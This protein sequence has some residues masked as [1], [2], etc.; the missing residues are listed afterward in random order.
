MWALVSAPVPSWLA[1]RAARRRLKAS[2][3]R[4]TANIGLRACSI[5]SAEWRRPASCGSTPTARSTAPWRPRS[6]TVPILATQGRFWTQ[7]RSLSRWHLRAGLRVVPVGL[8]RLVG[9]VAPGIT[10][11]PQSQTVLAGANV[12]FSVGVTPGLTVAYQWYLNT[13]AIP[14]ATNSTLTLTNVQNANAGSYTV[15]VTNAVTFATSMRRC[16]RS[17]RRSTLG[18]SPVHRRGAG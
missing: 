15:A 4:P 12:T 5:P 17:A 18:S 13:V 7:R 9:T 2:I 14:G 6:L 10:T 3:L 11:Q 1:N 8:T 16:C